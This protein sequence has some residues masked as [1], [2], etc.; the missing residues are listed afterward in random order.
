MMMSGYLFGKIF[1]VTWSS[2]VLI[3]SFCNLM[4]LVFSVIIEMAPLL[5]NIVFFIDIF[6]FIGDIF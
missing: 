1:V 5:L 3:I 4:A 6:S 2:S